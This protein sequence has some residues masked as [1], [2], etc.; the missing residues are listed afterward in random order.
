MKKTSLAILGGKPLRTK[1]FQPH[2]VI[3]KEERDQV[4]SVLRTGLLSGFIA[5][6]G[7]AFLGGPKTQLL[8][9]EIGRYFK[10]PYVVAMNSATSAL[11]AA[12]AALEIGPGDEVIVTPYTMSAS[13]SAILM[14]Q[15]IPVFADID[16]KTF[17]LDP[18]SIL[19]KITSR[20]RALVVVHLFGQP[21]PMEEIL[22]IAK[23]HHLRVVEDC[24]QS[25]GARFG[26]KYV[27]TLGDIGVFS[28]NQHKTITTGEGGFAIT[29]DKKLAM[30]LR[31]VRNHG[32][33]VIDHLKVDFDPGPVLG[34]NYRITELDAAVGV[35][36]FRKLDHL[37]GHRIRL[38]EFLSEE[39][40][41]I[42]GFS[43]PYR[44]PRSSHV[45]FLLALKYDEKVAGI[46]RDLFVK[47]VNAEG[48]SMGSGYVRPIYLD[49]AYRERKIYPRSSFPFDSAPD[50]R[51]GDCPVAE[52]M[53]FRKLIT[54]NL[55]R[56]PLSIDD[57]KDV[58]AGVR[59]VLDH[60]EQL[61]AR[62]RSR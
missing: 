7:P 19:K 24:A 2:P 20:T 28:L 52:E 33:V 31:L 42:K 57:M 48:I 44:R 38:A 49:R 61:L 53:H 26:G 58:V 47:A 5:N 54:T 34:W 25:P 17:C 12:L 1:P 18:K 10:V 6:A 27:G 11:H 29:R 30:R 36:Q 21:A 35:A 56:Y 9:S 23:Q 37:N 55:C 16:E 32:E 14:Q 4:A 59:K 13:A 15:A 45:Y 46:P 8:E 51:R 43:P 41:K 39:F 22:G 40:S 60:S 50:Y 3:G 62:E